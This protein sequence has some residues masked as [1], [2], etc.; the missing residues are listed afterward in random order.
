MRTGLCRCR[1]T[2]PKSTL[3]KGWK[4]IARFLGQPSSTAQCKCQAVRESLFRHHLAYETRRFRLPS[5]AWSRWGM[6]HRTVSFCVI[7]YL[8]IQY[9]L[10]FGGNEQVLGWYELRGSKWS[11]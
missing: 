5:R 3:L 8:N 6:P 2:K 9:F 11:R 10:Y 7:A 1:K 4:D